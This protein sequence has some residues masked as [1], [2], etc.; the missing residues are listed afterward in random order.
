MELFLLLLLFVIVLIMF[1]SQQGKLLKTQQQI[2]ELKKDVEKLQKG[3]HSEPQNIATTSATTQSVEMEQS[4]P[5]NNTNNIL[6]QQATSTDN[7]VAIPATPTE[8]AAEPPLTKTVATFSASTVEKPA[9]PAVAPIREEPAKVVASN[10]TASSNHNDDPLK[11][12]WHWLVK[13]NPVA[14]LAIIILFFGL[15]YLLKY[16]IE[17]SLISPELRILGSLGLGIILLGL[18]WQLRK[19]KELY[20]LILQGGAI[21]ILY[22]TIF[23]AIKLYA[24][25]P[26]LL[27]F[28]LL[29]VICATSVM[30]A[31]LQRAISLAV[32]ACLG[33]YLAPVLLSTGAGSH[34]ALFSY[35]LMLSMAILCISFWQSW[36]ILNLI[37]FFFTFIIAL[38]WGMERYQPQFY[39]ECQF[40]IISNLLIYGVLAVVLSI[41]SEK[42]EKY[43]HIID[44]ILLFGAPLFGFSLQYNITEQ[45]EF[46]PAFASLGFG[47]F[48]IIGAYITLKV[49]QQ[50]AKRTALYGLAIGIGFSTLAIPLAFTASWTALVWLIEGAAITW[51]ALSQRQ[52]RFAWIGSTIT[53]FGCISTLFANQ[54]Y[55][56]SATSFIT[57]YGVMS[58]ILLFSACLWHHYRDTHASSKILKIIFIILAALGWVIW[59]IGSM[60]KLYFYTAYSLQ[61]LTLCFVFAVWLWYFIGKKQNWAV[62]QYA[63]IALWPVLLLSIIENY[64]AE[65]QFYEN[66]LWALS[67]LLA[68]GSAYV[69]LHTSTSLLKTIKHLPTILHIS[70]FWLV[71][72]RLTN[73]VN[74]A[75]N[76]LPWGYSSLG[77]SISTLVAGLVILLLAILQKR[78]YFPTKT[79]AS[80]YWFIGLIP[81]VIF[82]IIQLFA[83]LYS[84]G[85]IL[86]WQYIPFI[87]PVEEVAIFGWLMLFVWS[88]QSSKIASNN[89]LWLSIIHQLIPFFNGLLIL[90]IF[91]WGNSVLLRSLS[92]VLDIP[93]SFYILWYTSTVQVV[94]SLTWTLIAL[95]L[96]VIA[97]RYHLR[98]AWFAGAILQ[99]IVVI[100]LIF[101]DSVELDGLMRAF[102]FIGV[103]L[104]MLVIG[105][106]APIP[107]K[108]KA[109]T[110]AETLDELNKEIK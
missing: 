30:F 34:I 68:F 28:V 31:V 74:L 70:L 78:E 67:S 43:Q 89:T 2:L 87:N 92:T 39:P 46:G 16:S 48:Y 72:G 38:F 102:V 100:K 7:I 66:G 103:A 79:N 18:G 104:L 84:N 94:F 29:V 56:L 91:L 45:W 41:R 21:G 12:L 3:I 81:V 55:S 19:K 6:A 96:V 11:K 26:M 61:P 105:Y 88:R 10:Q 35:Y 77:W 110:T 64:M 71:L 90:F 15:S 101:V 97:P 52:Y 22:L 58:G 14:K 27:A 44:L 13:D 63:V 5:T 76:Q 40:F 51:A 83:G 24:L 80:D 65:R 69:Y 107:P 9:K 32:I 36:R 37:G 57:L 93:W 17:H 54:S 109:Q 50:L 62:L 108:N 73:E 98:K 99:A 59:I 33:G 25:I 20:A 86:N 75:I 82:I 47:L 95:M 53:L 1:S 23:A 4:K 42:S 85:Q 106:L 60:D 49:W 8:K